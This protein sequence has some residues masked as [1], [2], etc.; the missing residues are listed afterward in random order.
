MM[1]DVDLHSTTCF[2]GGEYTSRS[3]RYVT[4]DD[5]QEHRAKID[6]INKRLSKFIETMINKLDSY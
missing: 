3:H 4:E 1:S 6:E 2:K 5:E